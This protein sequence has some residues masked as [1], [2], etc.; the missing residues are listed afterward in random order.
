MC[1]I[2]SLIRHVLYRSNSTLCWILIRCYFSQISVQRTQN[3]TTS[4]IIQ[5]ISLFFN[6]GKRDIV[7]LWRQVEHIDLEFEAW[8]KS[9]WIGREFTRAN[10]IRST[11]ALYVASC[12]IWSI[13][14]S[15]WL[16]ETYQVPSGQFRGQSAIASKAVLDIIL[17]VADVFVIIALPLK[18]GLICAFLIILIPCGWIFMQNFSNRR[19]IYAIL[20]WDQDVRH[21]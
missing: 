11:K 14:C 1:S 7:Q 9:P 2:Y 20:A 3:Y 5:W 17:D 16:E 15:C 10:G 18:H 21:C 4:S 13:I 12:L 19:R 6:F 8:T